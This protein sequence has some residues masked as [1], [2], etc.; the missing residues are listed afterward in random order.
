MAQ[1]TAA[2]AKSNFVVEVSTDGS[3]WTNISGQSASVTPGGGDQHTGEQ[4]TADGNAPVVTASNKV[5]AKTIEVNCL[6]TET[7][8]EAWKVVTA[9]YEGSAKTIYL[10]YSPEGGASGDE[11]FTCADD[12]GTAAA[13]PIVNCQHPEGDAS[14][15]DPLMFTFSVIAPKLLA[16][17]IA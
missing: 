16:E 2:N 12:A 1:T 10:R 6:Y 3:A 5:A 14:T 11:R 8:G 7:S 9:R 13:V 17:T 4:N 15:G